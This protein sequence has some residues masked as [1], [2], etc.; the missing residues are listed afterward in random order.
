M[1]VRNA[2]FPGLAAPAPARAAT[3]PR[4]GLIEALRNAC[5]QLGYS[6]SRISRAVADDPAF[7]FD[8][9]Q[10]RTP[11]PSTITRVRA[12]LAE[13]EPSL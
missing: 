12:K 2:R 10:G 8:L 5:R 9:E 4:T 6:S 3:D 7:L 1:L 13:L 11:R